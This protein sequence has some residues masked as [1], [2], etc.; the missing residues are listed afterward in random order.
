M[1]K[2]SDIFNVS[3]PQD[4]DPQVTKWRWIIVVFVLILGLNGVMGRGAFYGFGAY[5]LASDMQKVD[6][7]TDRILTLQIASAL[8]DLKKEEC[9]SNG[10]KH[11]IRSTIEEYQEQ[12]EEIKGKRYP[13]PS[14]E[15]I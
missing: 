6:T 8:R 12:Y 3:P 1:I 10:N 5:A 14:C 13:L 7:K 9:R 2:L 4:E 11:I 15:N